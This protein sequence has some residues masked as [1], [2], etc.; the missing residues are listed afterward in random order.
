[1]PGVR[2]IESLY[3][4][5]INKFGDRKVGMSK[6]RHS[7][8]GIFAILAMALLAGC[9]SSG[10]YTTTQA[11]MSGS[12]TNYPAS[13]AWTGEDGKGVI[14]SSDR[15]KAEKEAEAAEEEA[16]RAA[17]TAA[18]AAAGAAAAAGAS[19]GSTV[20]TEDQSEFE[21][22]KAEQ[23][24]SQYDAW[25]KSQEEQAAIPDSQR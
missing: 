2:V 7:G 21:Q 16:N 13:G 15:S 23:E 9:N 25:K 6:F 1:L 3:Y 17:A 22:W 24:Q 10:G 11:K 4:F 8:L 12:D 5:Q 14:Y 18:G 20:P 19:S